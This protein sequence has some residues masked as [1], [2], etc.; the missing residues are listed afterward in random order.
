MVWV[1]VA[2]LVVFF[3]VLGGSIYLV[4]Q[5]NKKQEAKTTTSTAVNV[6]TKAE[7]NQNISDLGTSL[8][9]AATDQA[10]AKAAIDDQPVKVGN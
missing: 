2:S 10:A 4:L 1:V 5:S 8:K 7:V 3:A 6:V 9:Q